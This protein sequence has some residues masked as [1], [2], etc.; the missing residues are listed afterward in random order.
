MSDMNT[1][2]LDGAAC[3]ECGAD[4]QLLAEIAHGSI[5]K[6]VPLCG[7]CYYDLTTRCPRRDYRIWQRDGY[8]TCGTVDLYCG[9]C[10]SEIEAALMM[11]ALYRDEQRDD[12]NEVKR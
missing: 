3:K 8:R 10:H 2:T 6:D 1:T 7:T 5:L 4:A 9:S 11:S 12:V